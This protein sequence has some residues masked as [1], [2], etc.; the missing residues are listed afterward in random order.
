ML[1]H[2][3][4]IAAVIILCACAANAQTDSGFTGN[5]KLNPA[6]SE[7][8]AS[9]SPPDPFLK[10]DQSPTAL[11]VAGG[12]QPSG[13]FTTATYPLDGSTGIGKMGDSRTSS[14]TKWEGAALLV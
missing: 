11:T 7:M 3:R 1:E 2:M 8:R 10:V 9:P 5:W 13:P 4:P 6:R 12:S 14:Q